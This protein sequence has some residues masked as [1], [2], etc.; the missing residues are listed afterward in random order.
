MTF[1]V[2][3]ALMLCDNDLSKFKQIVIDTM[4]EIGRK[5]I[6]CGFGPSFYYWLKKIS[7]NLM[8]VMAMVLLCE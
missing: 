6:N 8:V 3:K 4:V 1:A 2:A 5:Y 7:T